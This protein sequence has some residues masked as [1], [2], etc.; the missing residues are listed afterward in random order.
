MMLFLSFVYWKTF[1]QNNGIEFYYNNTDTQPTTE[2]GN[3]IARHSVDNSESILNRLINLFRLSD[4]EWYQS[5]TSKTIYY[6]KWIVNMALALVS[7]ISLVFIIYWFYLMFFSKDEEWFSKAKK[8][9]KG[10]LIALV[11]MWLSWLIVSFFFSTQQTL[12]P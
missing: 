11:I 12:A 1:A 5:G 7:F 2:L 9:L 10:V 6:V 8:I 3:E 4:N